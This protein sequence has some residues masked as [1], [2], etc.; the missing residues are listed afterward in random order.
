MEVLRKV[1]VKVATDGSS[2]GDNGWGQSKWQ[3]MGAVDVKPDGGSGGGTDGGTGRLVVAVVDGRLGCLDG[4][5][6]CRKVMS[7]NLCLYVYLC[8]CVCVCV[9]VCVRVGVYA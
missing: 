4:G 2:G 1:A 7:V 8:I 3:R 6:Y 9:R 5:N